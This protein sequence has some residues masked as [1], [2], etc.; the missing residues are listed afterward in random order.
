MYEFLGEFLKQMTN[1]IENDTVTSQ[2][3]HE[4]MLYYTN[5]TQG[6]SSPEKYAGLALYISNMFSGQKTVEEP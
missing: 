5:V 6:S 3:L 1:K 2:E 4:T